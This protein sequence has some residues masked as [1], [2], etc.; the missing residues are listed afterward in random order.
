MIDVM[1]KIEEME[2]D[3]V[4]TS[5]RHLRISLLVIFAETL[6]CLGYSYGGYVALSFLSWLLLMVS[7]WAVSLLLAWM[8]TRHPPSWLRGP[9]QVLF[10]T[11]WA[12]SCFL[13]TSYFLDQYRISAV[14]FS[15]P[16]LLMSS[17]RLTTMTLVGVCSFATFGYLLVL[18]LVVDQRSL[19]INLSVEGLQWIIFAATNFSFVISGSA[20]SH[21]QREL[22]SVSR[23]LR[24]SAKLA[25]EQA[26]RDELT[27]L[28]N[29][30]QILEILQ[31]QRALAETG[32]YAF[33]VC[34]LDLDHF[35]LINDA[36][37]HATGDEVLVR[38]AELMQLS[39]RDADYCGRLGGEEFVLILTGLEMDAARRV[40]E[41]LR[42][43]LENWDFGDPLG[44]GHVT[45]SAGLAQYQAPE[46]VEQ[47][48][49]RADTLL[50]KAKEAGRNCIVHH[51]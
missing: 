16:I 31:Q 41:R 18:V 9:R 49:T 22:V 10:L 42:A 44:K 20:V 25:R 7:I 4:R 34:Y 39:V 37:G 1:E 21:T 24:E 26:I 32:D 51:D 6:M 43:R 2:F 46:T 5:A 35:K 47:L 28:F 33:V 3:Q 36:H 14:M 13:V 30:R 19:E 27:G 45:L 17:F 38:A 8:V 29:R 12:T 23:E 48:L 50:Y 40:V 11:L 15:F